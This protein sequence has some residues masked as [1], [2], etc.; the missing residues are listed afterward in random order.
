MMSTEMLEA[1]LDEPRGSE[2]RRITRNAP[3]HQAVR[4]ERICR[5]RQA[6]ESGAYENEQRLRV[7]LDR[8]LEDMM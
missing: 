5:I 1:M 8:L 7:A 3:D 4:L 2:D 6:I